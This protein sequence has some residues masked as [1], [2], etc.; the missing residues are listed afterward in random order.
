MKKL[1]SSSSSNLLA[2]FY[3]R[4]SLLPHHELQECK[5]KFQ[6]ARRISSF[7][8]SEKVS[9]LFQEAFLGGG[10]RSS[11]L[12]SYLLQFSGPNA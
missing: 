2:S 3:Q 11:F 7:S 1:Y 8:R 10:F 9:E 4:L 12:L 6:I 5:P